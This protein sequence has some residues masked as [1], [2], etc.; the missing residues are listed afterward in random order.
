MTNERESYKVQ[1]NMVVD[2]GMIPED[3]TQEFKDKIKSI[4]YR[5]SFKLRINF[6]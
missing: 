4:V 6:V 5:N 1:D 2:H 3:I